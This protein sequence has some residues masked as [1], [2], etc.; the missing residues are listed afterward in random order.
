MVIRCEHCQT[1]YQLDESMLLDVRAIRV[2]CRKCGGRIVVMKPG[3]PG[4][5]PVSV[6]PPQ[7]AP[8]PS[9]D[10]AESGP[11]AVDAPS[12][13]NVVFC[14]EEIT[15]SPSL[16]DPVPS[17][18]ATSAGK[19]GEPARQSSAGPGCA[20]SRSV[21]L[22]PDTMVDRRCIAFFPAAPAMGAYRE[23]RTRILQAAEGK[24]GNTV[25]VTSALPLEGKTLTAINLALTFSKTYQQT[26]LLVDCDLRKQDIH[27]TLGFKSGLGLGDY[28]TVGCEV[29]DMM[30][31]PGVEKLTLISGG[32]TVSDSS[33]LLGSPAMKELV[34]DM[35]G[36]YP[37][38]YVFFDV[39][40]ILAG[41]DALAFSPLVDHILFVV[42]ADTTPLP[43]VQK[44]LEMLP[45]EKVIGLVL[46][47]QKG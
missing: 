38:R 18:P 15:P 14:P 12:R 39:P 3:T 36:R 42:R 40:P 34:E 27:E 23:L 21:V 16:A 30:V 19:A 26:A 6:M 44:A 32:T 5:P 22:D 31:W 46:N 1:R 10:A 7:G 37:G 20:V 13:G 11:R 29:S 9:A 41:A 45:R 24:G 33:E 2:D 28:L 47:R 35:K 25:M 43:E 8:A 17:P 4:G